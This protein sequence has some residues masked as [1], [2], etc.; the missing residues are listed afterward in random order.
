MDVGAL[1]FYLGKA[2]FQNKEVGNG[3]KLRVVCS[4]VGE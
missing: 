3:E 4:K 1:L 2:V